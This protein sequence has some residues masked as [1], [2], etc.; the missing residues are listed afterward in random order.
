MDVLLCLSPSIVLCNF[1]SGHHKLM[2]DSPVYLLKCQGHWCCCGGV[3]DVITD[4]N[5][6]GTILVAR[7]MVL[8]MGMVKGWY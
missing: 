1:M 8:M 5:G 4:G 6:V 7:V 2:P 3:C